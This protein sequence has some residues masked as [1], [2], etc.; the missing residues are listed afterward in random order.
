MPTAASLLARPYP[1]ALALLLAAWLVFLPGALG[2]LRRRLA[3]AGPS[4]WVPLGALLLGALVL[5]L[6]LPSAHQVYYD[7]FEHLDI[8]RRVAAAGSFAGTLAGGLEG[9]DVAS[10]PT[11]PGGHHVALA[12]AFRLFGAGEATAFAWSA[13]LS[14]LTALFVFWAA[15]EAFD[16]ERGALAAAFVWAASPL[17]LRWG[18]A[19]DLTSS[20]LFWSA[21]ALA[22]LHARR[23]DEALGPFAAL[24]LAY[25]VQVRPEN[26]LLLGYAAL[27]RA[28]ARVILPGLAGFAFPAAIALLNRAEALPGYSASTTSP[29]A[30]L[31]RQLG[32]NLRFLVSRPECLLAVLPGV[33]AAATRRRA[34]ALGAL[35]ACFLLLYGCFFRGRF[36][37][38]TEDRY[39]LSVLLPLVVAGAAVLPQAAVPAAL[40]AAGLA[41]RGPAP[42]DARNAESRRFLEEAASR[43]PE[44][45]YVVAF[46]PRS[47]ARPRAAPRPGPICSSR[48][49]PPSKWRAPPR[50]RPR[51][52]RSTRTGPGARAPTTP[53]GWRRRSPR[54]TPRRSS[55]TTGGT[56]SCC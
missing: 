3:Q 10:R 42:A 53:R 26:F 20:S 49:F 22:A 47:C 13:V 14:A 4:T 19:A 52:W 7:E 9:W 40:L 32:P 48:T 33:I 28:P 50:A 17:A 11:W 16:D 31:A 30:H 27:L 39:A 46:N 45:A 35:A 23:N 41:W 34:A 15:L 8:A 36:D 56:R 1:A 55:P 38:G 54:A 24:T 51:S 12:A 5:R 44:R 2:R 6:A 43:L 21:A 25:S 37:A 18:L 29:L